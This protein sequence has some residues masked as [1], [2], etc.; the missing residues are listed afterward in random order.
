V[1]WVILFVVRFTPRAVVILV[2]ATVIMSAIQAE[3]GAT[4]PPKAGVI[5]ITGYKHVGIL[6][7]SGPVVVV[8]KGAKAAAIRTALAG[9][10]SSPS[11][12][13]CMESRLAFKVSF[14]SH[15]GARPAYV[16]TEHDC[17]TPGLVFIRVGGRK[18]QQLT[19]DCSLRV[20][21]IAALPRGQAEGT[22][23]DDNGCSNVAGCPTCPTHVLYGPTPIRR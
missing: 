10:A 21:V 15:I 2:L 19:E 3:V 13:G 22:R 11:I 20:A 18:I 5:E 6:G 23:R 17:P 9:L 14:L 7:N 1:G 4:A 12:S 16:A 8:A